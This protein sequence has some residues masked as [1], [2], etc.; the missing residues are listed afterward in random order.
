MTTNGDTRV[1][2]PCARD[3]AGWRQTKAAAVAIGSAATLAACGGG[4]GGSPETRNI[5]VNRSADPS[6][7]GAAVALQPEENASRFLSQAG[8]GATPASISSLVGMGG[9]DA[10]AYAAYSAWLDAQFAMTPGPSLWQTAWNYGFMAAAK[11]DGD[12][13][14][15]NLLWYRLFTA[16][17]ELRQRIVLALSE[18]FVVSVRNM[19]VPWGQ[20][21]CLAYWDLLEQ[22]CFG[23]F[24][25]LIEAITLSPAMGVYLSMRGSQKA[26]AVSGRRP[27]ENYA[28]ELMQLFTIGLLHL[29]DAGQ[30]IVRDGRSETYTND[31]VTQLAKALTGWDVDGVIDYARPD[32]SLAYTNKP[33][34]PNEALHDTSEKTILGQT[35]PAGQS[36]RADLRQALDIICAHPNVGPFI[37]R[38]LIQRLVSSNPEPLHIQRVAQVFNDNGQG[39]RGD[40]KAVIKAV[41]TDPLAREP[42]AGDQALRRCKLRE[43]LMR[44]IQWGRLVG[45]HSTLTYSNNQ[46]VPTV[47]P[48]VPVSRAPTLL[49]WWNIGDL[50]A[51]NRLAQS[52]LRSPSVFNFFRPGYVPL[53]SG[54][55]ADGFV[56]PEFQI[57]DES[58]VIGYANFMLQHIDGA[59]QQFMAVDHSAWLPLAPDAA[60]LVDNINLLLTGRALAQAT[61]DVIQKAIDKLDAGSNDSLLKRVKMA[62]Y[63]MQVSAD[64]MVQR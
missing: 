25:E 58:S 31:D 13:G 50:S 64:Y 44:F 29:D 18:I 42:L 24:R 1:D 40:M 5:D 45:L 2:D 10:G 19:A 17:D 26:D 55:S 27:D 52:P 61:V 8:L 53:N 20:F 36:A 14:M 7:Q 32:D 59:A 49:D 48:P 39:V 12:D 33:M 37:A 16:Q 23:T 30:P 22:H 9:P 35:I 47:T 62:F 4:G 56:A 54:L 41:L 63:L 51:A 15:D 60:R 11:V 21:N 38:Q 43:P 46:G 3:I 34:V 57:T 28:R 6:T